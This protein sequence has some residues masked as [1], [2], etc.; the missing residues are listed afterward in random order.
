M[1]DVSANPR[2]IE[3]RLPTG[4]LVCLVDIPATGTEKLISILDAHFS[5]APGTTPE[6]PISHFPRPGPAPQEGI[7]RHESAYV[8]MLRDPVKRIV[9]LYDDISRDARHE[10]HRCIME[11]K[12]TLS[13]FVDDPHAAGLVNNG[14][15]RQLA[16]TLS[17][18]ALEPGAFPDDD[19]LPLAK[20]FLKRCAFVGLAERLG[21]SLFLLS[22]VFGWKSVAEVR[23]LSPIEVSAQD[24][25]TVAARNVV[26][27]DLYRFAED[28]F[29]TRL[30]RVIDQLL[31][32]DYCRTVDERRRV[33]RLRELSSEVSK[34]AAFHLFER[35]VRLRE[36][37]LPP[38]SVRDRLYTRLRSRLKKWTLGR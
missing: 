27:I 25:A 18:V 14:Q 11:R 23:H 34:S 36:Q 8:T 31:A 7:S 26:D 16:A 32:E 15:A 28:L 22:C 38:D 5:P 35:L 9:S 37:A 19:L 21:E 33:D 24:A 2:L 10:L 1:S 17:G 13:A 20:Q 30:I 12:L 6:P 4:E 29:E 3:Y